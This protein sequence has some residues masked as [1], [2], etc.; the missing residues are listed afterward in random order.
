MSPIDSTSI[1]CP[2]QLLV[3]GNDPRNFFP[4]FIQQ[5][6]PDYE[7]QVRNY[8]GIGELRDYLGGFVKRPDFGYVKNLGLVRDA[9]HSAQSAFQSVQDALTE[10]GLSS[11]RQVAVRSEAHPAVTVLIWPSHDQ[12]GML[13][14]LL[15]QSF[16]ED[17]LTECIDN[18]FACLD[19][20]SVSIKRPDK[21]R[22][23]VYL[24]TKPEAHVSVG[25]AAQKKYWNLEHAAFAPVH[26]FIQGL[27]KG[28]QRIG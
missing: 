2:I 25:V 1:A 12:P 8:G 16:A 6:Y 7:I 5:Q 20:R 24:T 10:V 27:H 18:F 19:E 17:P 4:A 21:A 26:A 14:T 28:T 9:E 3:E 22:A 15:C 13:E 11:P 23:R